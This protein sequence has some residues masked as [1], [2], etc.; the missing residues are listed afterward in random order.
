VSLDNTFKVSSKVTV[1]DRDRTRV[2]LLKGGVLSMIN[3]LN[4]IVAWVSN[5]E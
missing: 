1:V 4:F 3:E 5:P 2:K